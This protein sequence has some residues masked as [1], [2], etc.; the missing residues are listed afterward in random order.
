MPLIDDITLDRIRCENDIVEVIGQVVK[1]K[2]SGSSWKGICPFHQEK[3]PSFNVNPNTNRFH[4]FGCGVS[5]DV[6]DF[7]RQREGIDF[8]SAAKVAAD[9]AGIPLDL[10]A[11]PGLT[12]KR[13]K[14]LMPPPPR[15]DTKA[16]TLLPEDLCRWPDQHPRRFL[17]WLHTKGISLRTA[18]YLAKKN[19][20]GLKNNEVVFFYESGVKVRSR[21]ED[22]HSS[23]WAEGFAE[24]PWLV[25]ELDSP[26]ITR[27]Y[28]CE[29]ESDTM[30]LIP[31]AGPTER[32]IGLPGAS[33]R[34]D[35]T[36]CWRIGALREVVLCCDGDKAGRETEDRLIPLFQKEAHHCRIGNLG[37]PA[38][39]DVCTLSKNFLTKVVADPIWIR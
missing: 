36:M 20:L 31:F 5:G 9:R 15:A 21:M 11:K 39:K 27:V 38:D 26:D 6:I 10:D 22:S 4:C 8:Q 30:R 28:L 32:V 24:S 12:P 17:D 25:E 23:W 3:S 33:W 37:V 29:G 16:T 2:R 7:F 1:L 34:P 19:Y 13:F 14:K 35:P 18:V